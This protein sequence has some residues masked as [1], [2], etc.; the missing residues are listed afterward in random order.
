MVSGFSLPRNPYCTLDG[1]GLTV[2]RNEDDHAVTLVGIDGLDGGS[3]GAT[4][5]RITRPAPRIRIE[6]FVGLFRRKRTK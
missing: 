4:S 3:T 1:T 6:S 5:G 2:G